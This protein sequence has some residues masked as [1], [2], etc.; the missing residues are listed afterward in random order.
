MDPQAK[1]QQLS[2]DEFPGGGGISL[3]FILFGFNEQFRLY[4][5]WS[6]QRAGIHLRRAKRGVRCNPSLYGVR[7]VEY[8][9][10]KISEWQQHSTMSTGPGI[11]AKAAEEAPPLGDQVHPLVHPGS[12]GRNRNPIPRSD[13][14]IRRA[15]TLEVSPYPR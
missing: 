1:D 3:A 10:Q 6:A 12:Q 2:R 11:G 14:P 5:G 7:P 13:T 15:E 4:T 9:V 8:I